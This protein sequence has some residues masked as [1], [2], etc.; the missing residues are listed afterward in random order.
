MSEIIE[1]EN[2]LYYGSPDCSTLT[3]QALLDAVSHIL[4]TQSAFNAG[5]STELLLC[6]YI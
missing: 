6:I 2:V 5:L 1:L 3:T 4:N